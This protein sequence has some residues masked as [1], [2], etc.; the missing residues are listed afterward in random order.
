[1]Q[2]LPKNDRYEVLHMAQKLCCCGKI[3]R[4]KRYF[5]DFPESPKLWLRIEYHVYIWLV[6]P[7]PSG[8]TC[9]ISGD[10]AKNLSG[11]IIKS[12]ISLTE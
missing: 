2:I 8:D 12:E 7:Q 6:S 4:T 1:M 3:I 5:P 10:C 9:Q 11:I